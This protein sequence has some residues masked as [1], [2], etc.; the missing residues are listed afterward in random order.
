MWAPLDLRNAESVGATLERA[1]ELLRASP[2]RRGCVHHLPAHG[3]LVVAGDLHDN[4][5]HLQRIVGFARLERDEQNHVVLQEL[6]HGDRLVNGVDL[7]YRVVARVAELVVRFPSQVHPLLANHELCQM[8]GIGVSKGYGDGTALFNDGLDFVFGDD[9][10]FV[11]DMLAEFFRAMPLAVRT[12]GGLWCSHSI[13]SPET[14]DRF[15][16]SVL[17]RELE[18]A[19]YAAPRGSA[20]LMV[21][22]R[23]Q[24]PEQVERLASLLD[25]RLFCLGHA[26]SEMGAHSVTPR[27]AVINSDHERGRVAEIDL[28]ALPVDADDLVMSTLPLAA[29]SDGV[30]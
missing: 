13:P 19:D 29:L 27:M 4:P 14:T 7:S 8:L 18:S 6:I 17:G 23:G 5:V 30:A 1:A 24:V 16:P 26:M 20:Y 22:G 12:D 2:F 25:V 15:D 9:A 21:W 10:Q 28:A 3:R 11:A